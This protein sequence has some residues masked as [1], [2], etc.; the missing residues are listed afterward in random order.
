MKQKVFQNM[1]L[2]K[3]ETE[4][5]KKMKSRIRSGNWQSLRAQVSRKT[6][7]ITAVSRNGYFDFPS[8]E[9]RKPEIFIIFTTNPFHVA[10]TDD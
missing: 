5:L 4:L 6:E 9:N 1:F 7:V 3:F 8:T 10:A 2:G